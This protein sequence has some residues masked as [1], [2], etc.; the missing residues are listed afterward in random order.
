MALTVEDSRR[1]A[2]TPFGAIA[3]IAR[4]AAEDASVIRW[5]SPRW[6]DDP[7]GF[8]REVLGTELWE[9]QRELVES[10]RDNRNTTCRSGHK[11]GKTTA[12]AVAALWFFASFEDARV[13]M[14]AVKAAQVDEAMWREVRR[15]YRRAK[16]RGYDL[17]GVLGEKASYGLRADDGR[18]IWGVVARDGEG[19]AGL[20]GPNILLLIDEASGVK[21]LFFEVLGSSL[22]GEGGTVRKCYISNPTRTTGEFYKSHTV[23]K[24]LFKCIHI[25]S[26]D[27]P[28][29]RGTGMFPGLAGPTWIGEKKTE[30][31]EDSPSYRIR[32]KGDFVHDKDGKIISLNLIALAQAAWDDMPEEGAL[33][34]GVDPAGDGVI[35]DQSS[36]AIR[37]GRKLITV[38][39][40][41]S[42]SEDAIVANVVD[43][44]RT[45]RRKGEKKPRV[46]IDAEGGIGTRVAAKLQVHLDSYPDDFDLIEVRSGKK[47]WGSPEFATIR[48]GLWGAL[49]KWMMAGGAIPD[50]AKL[51]EDINAPIF[52]PD[53]DQRY[54]AT[55]KKELKKLLGRS[56]DR[57]DAACLACWKFEEDDDREDDD[58]A[59]K[60]QAASDSSSTDE[61]VFDAPSHDPYGAIGVWGRK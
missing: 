46:A 12:L 13:L 16:R 40:W 49:Q 2:V 21:D 34:I 35:A 3:E 60:K 23:N 44:A 47:M 5:P 8:A 28:N 20:S 25:S 1:G 11:C 56:P 10:I 7:V 48:D 26:E 6:R 57:G 15:L 38:P 55:P 29:A 30:Y 45:Y 37:R 31:G 51:S 42:I 18:Q 61:D 33:Q 24:A 22:A 36:I 41:Q 58:V 39:A 43:A 59:E 14:T 54:V 9:K 4:R 19:L 53:K 52:T 27:T 50:D 32:V 17:G